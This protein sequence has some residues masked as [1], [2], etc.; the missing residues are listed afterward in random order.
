MEG[1]VPPRTFLRSLL[2]RR[3][4]FILVLAAV[5]A[6]CVA[7]GEGAAPAPDG[8]YAPL[9]E[10]PIR[11]L[12]PEQIDAYAS[13]KGATMALPAELNGHPGPAHALD[14]AERLRLTPEQRAEMERLRDG[15]RAD[16][17]EKGEELLA[18]HK[19]LDDGFRNATLDEDALAALLQEIGRK[20]AELRFVHLRAHFEAAEILTPHQKALYAELRGYGRAD[21]GSHEH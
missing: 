2:A 21:H 4:P 6:G 9:L 18:L 1:A 13:G 15:M 14:L 17:I 5:L 11:G 10:S 8:S 3:A 19:A 7:P 20:D 16:A 12:T